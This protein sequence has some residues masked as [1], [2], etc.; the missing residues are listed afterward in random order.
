MLCGLSA[1]YAL[2]GNMLLNERYATG[3]YAARLVLELILT[4]CVSAPHSLD[5]SGVI[6]GNVKELVVI[7]SYVSLLCE[8]LLCSCVELVVNGCE[9][10]SDLL[11]DIV[12]RY[13]RLLT[14]Y[15]ADEHAAVV[16]DVARTEL[17]TERN[18]LHLVLAEL[19]AR[20]VVAVIKL[21][22]V[23]LGKLSRYLRCLL[24]NSLL[25]LS[26]GDKSHLNGGYLRRQDKSVIVSVSHD[27]S[28]DHTGRH[29]PGR[30]VRIAYL[31]LAIGIG[32]IKCSCKAVSEIVGCTT[33][34]RNT[35]V[36]HRLDGI[37]LHSARKLLLFGLASRNCGNSKSLAVKVLV[38]L[39]HA[40]S[41][42]SCL[43]LVLV[44]GMTLLPQKLGRTKERTGGLFP[45]YNVTPLIVELG[46]ISV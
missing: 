2:I 7:V 43:L 41:L 19:P 17:Q 39:E 15:A 30:L 12:K 9:R 16:L 10:L 14:A 26:N 37:G 32:Y 23:K 25:M 42:L 33:L 44:H 11:Y 21:N 31:V 18:T 38:A 36:H 5:K 45:S 20:G 22:A 28:T 46:K 34:K 3:F 13:Y 8:V 40:Q 6:L 4:L 35:V 27:Y 24:K 1:A 29:S